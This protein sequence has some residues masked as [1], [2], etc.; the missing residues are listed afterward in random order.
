MMSKIAYFFLFLA[1]SLSSN[2]AA[3]EVWRITSLDWEPYS[4]RDLP[5]QGTAID[6]LRRK[7]GLHGIRLEVDFFPWKRA[8]LLA[9]NSRYIG[10]FP[11]WRTEVKS[12]F[13]ASDN[14]TFSSLAIL[15]LKN[16]PIEYQDLN[17]LFRD[18]RVGLIK[19][20]QY[21][22]RIET[23]INRYPEKIIW[24]DNERSLIQ[25]LSAGRHAVA[26]TDPLVMGYQA[27]LLGI[28]NTELK[29]TMEK[30]PLVI[31]LRD[32]DDNQEVIRRLQQI[33]KQND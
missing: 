7:L 2:A 18:Y 23:L 11:A 29:Q 20:Y 13:V 32:D 25:K 4:G 21:P 17:E 8:Q 16:Q 27:Q 30:A 19:T 3:Q 15:G 1:V 9:K 6:G 22:S 33:L 28:Y 10:Y 12:G 14:V 24:A 5:G 31:A 26:L